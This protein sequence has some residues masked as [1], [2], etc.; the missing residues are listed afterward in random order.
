MTI[1]DTIGSGAGSS[2]TRA[3]RAVLVDGAGLGEPD[4]VRPKCGGEEARLLQQPSR[5]PIDRGAALERG[6]DEPLEVVDRPQAPG[7]GV[8][9]VEHG[10]HERRPH[11]EGRRHARRDDTGRSAAEQDL[12]LDPSEHVRRS[13]E[14]LVQQ[15][16]EAPAGDEVRERNRGALAGRQGRHP[17]RNARLERAAV[18]VGRRPPLDEPQVLERVPQRVGRA[19][20][21]HQHRR[22]PRLERRRAHGSQRDG[23]LE[24][25]QVRHPDEPGATRRDHA[26]LSHS[27]AR[28]RQSRIA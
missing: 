18:F 16:V 15:I 21:R 24:A 17:R 4:V 25:A 8:V 13:L 11:L 1:T 5:T 23:L 3:R 9:E 20:G 6:P 7:D 28:R 14:P 22:P 2:I 19:G 12:A 10:R 26:G 27:G